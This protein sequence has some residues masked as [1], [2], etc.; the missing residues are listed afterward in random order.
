MCVCVC[1]YV[2]VCVCV[3]LCVSVCVSVQGVSLYEVELLFEAS[4]RKLITWAVYTFWVELD[5]S[6]AR[7]TVAAAA[8]CVRGAGG[9]GAQGCSAHV[10]CI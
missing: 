6:R 4:V 9:G 3:C 8:L 7:R 2:R 1:V 5:V 10:D